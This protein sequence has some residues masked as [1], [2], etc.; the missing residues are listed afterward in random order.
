MPPREAFFSEAELVET[1]NAV[2]RIAA[3]PLT[4]YPPGM[5]VVVPGENITEAVVDYLRSGV[6]A[7]MAAPDAAD[8][9]LEHIRVVAHTRL[10]WADQRAPRI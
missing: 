7:G 9:R 10:P 1:K 6:A 8:H 3:E 5:P 4:P 2:G